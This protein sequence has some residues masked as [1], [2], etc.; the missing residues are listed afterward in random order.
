MITLTQDWACAIGSVC[1]AKN[2][3]IFQPVKWR[4]IDKHANLSH[5]SNL[6]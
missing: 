1:L 3:L 2:A 5:I 4:A 6:L